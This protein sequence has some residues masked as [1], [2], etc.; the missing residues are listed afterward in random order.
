MTCRKAGGATASDRPPRFHSA[1][2]LPGARLSHPLE[3]GLPAQS[4][5][6]HGLAACLRPV[7]RFRASKSIREDLA[8]IMFLFDFYA[9]CGSVVGIIQLEEFMAKTGEIVTCPVCSKQFYRFPSEAEKRRT[10][11]RACAARMFRDKGMTIQCA[12]CGSDFYRT[13]SKEKLG[14]GTTCS[15]ACHFTLRRKQVACNCIQCGAGFEAPLHRTLIPNGA[16]FCG[17]KCRLIFRRKL[18]KRGEQEMFTNWQKR[19]WK[20]G[21]CVRCNAT[22]TLELDHIIPRFAGGKAEK[23]NAQTLCRTCNRKKFWTDDFPLYAAYL[24]QRAKAV[25]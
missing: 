21:N 23:D 18:R 9:V 12:N 4:F 22:E 2:L 5:T 15:R 3:R 13:A 14:Y 11:S 6:L 24:K 17:H 25:C 19:E 20:D 7:T 1:Q 8:T 16:K 10:C